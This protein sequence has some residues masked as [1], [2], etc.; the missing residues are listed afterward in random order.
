MRSS[1]MVRAV[2]LAAAMVAVAGMA[3]AGENYRIDKVHTNVIFAI[4]HLKVSKFYGRFNDVSGSFTVDEGNP[5]A[6]TFELT[7]KADS[8]DTH[9]SKRDSHIKSPD[10]LNAKQF[11]V[12]T[13]KGKAV[14]RQGDTWTLKGEL[15]FHG[16]TKSV[17]V[18]FQRVGSGKDPWGNYRTGGTARFTIKRSEFGMDFMQGALGDEIEILVNIEGIRS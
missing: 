6:T 7:I 3:Y 11:P 4:E 13:F 2:L 1:W 12:I 16:V 5:E 17:T 14:G 15:M 18:E 9:S 10:F 8:V